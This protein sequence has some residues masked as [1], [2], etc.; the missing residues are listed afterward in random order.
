M[1]DEVKQF[2]EEQEKRKKAGQDMKALQAEIDKGKK[3][4]EERQKDI[5]RKVKEP[6]NAAKI[7]DDALKKM[8][9]DRKDWKQKNV[10]KVK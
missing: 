3:A 1:Q 6:K 2:K 9:Q 7:V 4:L 10:K 8:E 5:E